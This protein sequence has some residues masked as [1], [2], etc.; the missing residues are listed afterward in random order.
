MSESLR[1]AFDVRPLSGALGAEVL[2]V[3]LEDITDEE[4]AELRRLLLR[5]L[6]L[7]LPEQEGWSSE[8]RIAFGRRFGELEVHPYLPHLDGHPEIQIIDSEQDGKI[9][10]WHTDMTY[11]PNPPIGS[12]LQIVRSPGR[13]GDTMWSNQ[14]LAYESLSAP[15]RELLDGLTAIHAIH[16]PGLDSRAEHPVVRVH[17]ET[18]RR[19]L[20]VNRAHTSHIVQLS[21]NESDA[22]LQFLTEFSTSPQF[23]CRYQWRP[24]DVAIWDNRVTQHY[25]VDDYEERRTGLRV[26]VLGDDPTGNKPRWSPYRP[27]PGERYAPARVNAKEPY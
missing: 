15:M 3:R 24:G 4:F 1:T 17:P 2:G 9:P 12:V 19:A 14:Y 5:Y 8:S 13:G 25:A 6:V 10:I 27:K 18:G 11:S 22:L 16:I 20:F 21:R 23:T 7:F 26:V